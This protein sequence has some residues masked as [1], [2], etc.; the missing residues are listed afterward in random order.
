M[1]LTVEA[2]KTKW[3]PKVR[4]FAAAETQQFSTTGFN[5]VLKISED[6]TVIVA[7][8]GG[9]NCLASDCMMWR[10]SP[11]VPQNGYCGLA[12]TTEE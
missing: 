12:G 8:A 11:T 4:L 6:G 3:C 7:V 10:W 5:R 1:L 9:C 2:A